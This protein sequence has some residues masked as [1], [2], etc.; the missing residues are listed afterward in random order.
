M[1]HHHGAGAGGRLL[2]TAVVLAAVAAYLAGATRLRGRGDAWP[3]HRDLSFAAGGA[4]IAV[5]A[6]GTPPGGPFT[7]HMLQ[8]LLAGMAAPV[9]LVPAR[10]LTLAL[11]ALRPGGPPRRALLAAARSAPAR[12]LT[13]PPVAA[14][15]D[16]GGLWLMYR[17]PLLAAAHRHPALHALLHVHI[18]AA[19]LLFTFAV[20][21]LDPVRH[22]R[23]L[24][25]RAV[26]LLLAGAAHA[27]LAKSL[28]AAPPPGTAYGLSD[29]RTAARLM[30]Y[31]G[32][33]V[34]LALAAVLAASWYARAARAAGRPIRTGPPPPSQAGPRRLRPEG[35]GGEGG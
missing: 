14:V 5:A 11:R 23:G 19:G 2:A 10:P 16:M 34:E 20:C 28:Y 12:W 24:P 35:A 15:L 30:Y 7:V 3:R 25:L 32:D 9:L 4:L 8:H 13:F 21:Q 1:T 29:L 18:V 26:T 31:G 6:G 17:T 27:A 33:L 22:R